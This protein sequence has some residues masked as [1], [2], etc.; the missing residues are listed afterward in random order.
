MSRTSF[1]DGEKR[2]SVALG[3]AILLVPF[4]FAWFTLRPG[5]S[6]WARRFSV[7]YA[8]VAM[9]MIVGVGVILFSMRGYMAEGQ[10]DFD[11]FRIQRQIEHDA[12]TRNATDP[13]GPDAMRHAVPA[14]DAS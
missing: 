3:I 4:V 2:V 13:N 1:Q 9:V 11:R 14:G 7:G 6:Y 12:A 10:S 5:Y 8:V